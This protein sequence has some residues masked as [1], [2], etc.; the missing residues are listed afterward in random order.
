MRQ[1]PYLIDPLEDLLTP[2]NPWFVL[3][4]RGCGPPGATCGVVPPS[5]PLAGYP[6]YNFTT[7]PYNVP[8]LASTVSVNPNNPSPVPNHSNVMRHWAG[9]SE[10]NPVQVY[11][12]CPLT[13]AA[14]AAA[15]ASN[16][17]SGTPPALG[18]TYTWQTWIND[19]R[20]TF[21]KYANV[22]TAEVWITM[23]DVYADTSIPGYSSAAAYAVYDPLPA[24]FAPPLPA[25][26]VA[27][28]QLIWDYSATPVEPN[29]TG[30]TGNGF[31]EVIFLRNRTVGNGGFCS[32]D[33]NAQTG[34]IIECDVVFDVQSFLAPTAGLPSETTALNHEIGHFFGL[35]HTNLHPGGLF[36]GAPLVSNPGLLS[37]WLGY[38]SGTSFDPAQYPGMMGAIARFPG[39][40][41]VNT[42]PTLH[43][44]DAT[45]L[46][47]IYPVQAPHSGVAVIKD[48]LINTTATI[49]G[50]LYNPPPGKIGRFGD[51]MFLVE[52]AFGTIG[53]AANPPD[54]SLP[55]VGTIS[56]TARLAP[57]DVVGS[58]DTA[59]N[60]LSSGSFEIIGIPAPVPGGAPPYGRQYDVIAEDLGFSGSLGGFGYGEWYFEGWLNP[61]Q[62]MIIPIPNQTR[63]LSNDG[64]IG[65]T[66]PGLVSTWTPVP[67]VGSFS[68]VPGTIIDVGSLSH[69]GGANQP[70]TDLASRPLV[71]IVERTRPSP[72]G[73]VTLLSS[74]NYP[75]NLGGVS[76]TVN[77]ANFSLTQAGIAAPVIAGPT[78]TLTI[79]ANFAGF[80]PPAGY[81]ARLVLT[82]SETGPP[83]AGILFVPG[84]NHV[85]Y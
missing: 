69:V 71:Y 81:P 56:G 33:L 4:Y 2:D 46:S 53:G 16:I 83:P 82:A 13:M 85:Q 22:T 28:G 5:L 78:V 47:R 44:D 29:G 61:V 32:M 68:V 72:G 27:S 67:V 49:R 58:K 48:P 35:D 42:I 79:P 84:V 23:Q 8:S 26:L 75:L 70:F 73:V 30:P 57:A 66:L 25:P 20:T 10:D 19:V 17:F 76:L 34:A 59:A 14:A 36:V 21:L 51:N 18:I 43:I 3:G 1:T 7:P 6:N 37:S 64:F 55:G 45:G 80:L 77:G 31:N 52:R 9:M 38:A 24:P 60:A 15:P 40:N 63:F 74:S 39:K 12:S 41:M 65:G 62:N 50:R 11:I 54:P